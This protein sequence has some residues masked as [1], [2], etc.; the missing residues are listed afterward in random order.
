MPLELFDFALPSVRQTAEEIAAQVGVEVDFIRDKVGLH[1]RYILGPEETGVSLSVQACESLLAR[2]PHLRDRIG[3][4]VCVT[5]TPDQRMPH[6][7][8]RIAA[9]LGMPASTASFDVALGCSGY[10][11][12]IAILEGF[13]RATGQEFGL[14]VT[15]DPY[16]RLIAAEDRD[17]NAVFGDAATVTLVSAAETGRGQIL[18]TDF[19]SDNAQGCGLEIEAG[20]AAAPFVAIAAGETAS[21]DR[22]QLRLKMYGRSVFNFVLRNVPGSLAGVLDRAGIS[23]DEIDDFVLHQGSAYML[24]GL[25]KQARIPWEKVIVNMDRYGNTVS[26]SI[27]LC[28]AELDSNGKSLDGRRI[29]ISGFGVGFSWGS[30]VIA[31]SGDRSLIPHP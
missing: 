8:G 6:N 13:L 21:Y 16:S 25:A 19:G 23:L 14:L 15:C 10:V 22:D 3:T 11:Y 2:V 12:G 27:P 9:R 29:L 30:A 26:S 5:Q 4:V 7:A 20:G 31:F 1:Q 24:K 18:A 28:L 17:T